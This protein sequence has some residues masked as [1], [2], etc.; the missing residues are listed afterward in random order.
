M[1]LNSTINGEQS[2]DQVWVEH[3]QSHCPSTTMLS[4]SEPLFGFF[5]LTCFNLKRVQH[6]VPQ[7]RF[8]W[9]GTSTSRTACMLAI[10]EQN[11]SLTC[12][13]LQ[14]NQIWLLQ[15]VFNLCK[16]LEMHYKY[17]EEKGLGW[18]E[19][20]S[21][22]WT[23]EHP[24]CCLP[25]SPP[26]LVPPLRDQNWL[27]CQQVHTTRKVFVHDW[28]SIV[29]LGNLGYACVLCH[30]LLASSSVTRRSVSTILPCF[31]SLLQL[32]KVIFSSCC[33]MPCC[34]PSCCSVQIR[35][36]SSGVIPERTKLRESIIDIQMLLF[37]SVY[38]V[39]PTAWFF[40]MHC[41]CV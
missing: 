13:Y 3:S 27:L 40:M 11:W 12:L 16:L 17:Y 8:I 9:A 38:T 32:M 24:Y 20:G 23:I 6:N 37:F 31:P 30:D 35:P 15:L 10:R 39:I 14:Q 28:H 18:T 36:P 26:L 19:T 5:L 22:Y 25:E 7:E 21:G 1:C 4:L 29:F 41:P 2:P 33:G 34:A